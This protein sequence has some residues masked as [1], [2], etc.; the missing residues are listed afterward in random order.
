VERIYLE[1]LEPVSD[2]GMVRVGIFLKEVKDSHFNDLLGFLRNQYIE[3]YYFD[4]PLPDNI[5]QKLTYFDECFFITFEARRWSFFDL[6]RYVKA[7][8][9]AWDE[10]ISFCGEY[11]DDVLRTK[12]GVVFNDSFYLQLSRYIDR[13]EDMYYNEKSSLALFINGILKLIRENLQV[14]WAAAKLENFET[15]KLDYINYYPASTQ[16]HKAVAESTATIKS[17]NI[18]TYKVDFRNER[19]AEFFISP[20]PFSPA[21]DIIDTFVSYIIMHIDDFIY[22]AVSHKKEVFRLRQKISEL[23]DYN[24][25]L[26]EYL[27]K[28]TS[29]N[30]DFAEPELDSEHQ[31]EPKDLRVYVIGAAHISKSQL[32][33]EFTAAGFDKKNVNTMLEYKGTKTKIQ[34]NNLLRDRA[35]YDVLLFGPEPHNSI[36]QLIEDEPERYCRFVRVED[37]EGHLKITKKS[38]KTALGKVTEMMHEFNNYRI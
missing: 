29:G 18:I 25:S 17:D 32:I 12:D 37:K 9:T 24:A 30:I 11:L 23:Q 33:S 19:I 31:L 20:S 26:T 27:Q 1:C 34:I 36:L 22:G 5:Q 28:K 7:Y 13:C 3:C 8:I 21:R 15:G 14:Y 4:E 38:L 35:R 2:D 16:P 6:R 10:K